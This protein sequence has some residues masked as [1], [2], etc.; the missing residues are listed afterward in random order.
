MVA[1]KKKPIFDTHD[2]ILKLLQDALEIQAD[3]DTFVQTLDGQIGKYLSQIAKKENPLIKMGG[4]VRS[5]N[6]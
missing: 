1:E 6:R 3:T 5:P 2:F 4:Q